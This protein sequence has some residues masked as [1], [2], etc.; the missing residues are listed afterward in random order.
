MSYPQFAAVQIVTGGHG[1]LQF[2][3]PDMHPFVVDAAATPLDRHVDADRHR[4][5]VITK[6][7][8]PTVVQDPSRE[9]LLVI[10]TQDS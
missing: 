8:L 9:Q 10:V 3:Q 5:A 6:Q 7:L 1:F 4:Q 2:G